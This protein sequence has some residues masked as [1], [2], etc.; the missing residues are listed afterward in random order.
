M[1]NY[2]LLDIVMKMK[3]L[4]KA[5]GHLNLVTI[6]KFHVMKLCF[7]CGLYKQGLLH[8]LSKYSFTELWVGIKYFHGSKSPNAVERSVLGYSKAWLHHKGKNK[9]HY[10]YWVDCSDSGVVYGEMPVCYVVEMFLDRVVATMLYQKNDFDYTSP[11]S[12][13]VKTKSNMMMHATSIHILEELLIYLAEH[14]LDNTIEY[15]KKDILIR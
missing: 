9:H 14:G 10:E 4:K 5:K 7:R 6:H 8:D 11:Y 15:I 2:F 12:Y 3:T 13:F 1:K